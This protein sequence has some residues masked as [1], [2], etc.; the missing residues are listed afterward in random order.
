MSLKERM[1]SW[2]K[3]TTGSFVTTFYILLALAQFAYE[4]W[5]IIKHKED[6]KGPHPLFPDHEPVVPPLPTPKRNRIKDLIDKIRN[7]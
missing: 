4:I 1:S 6:D 3:K 5:K 7:R 2:G